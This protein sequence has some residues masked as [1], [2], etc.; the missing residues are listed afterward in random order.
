MAL[1]MAACAAVPPAP[2]LASR[3]EVRHFAFSGRLLIEQGGTRQRLNI[4]WQ[5]LAGEDRILLSTLLGQGVAE[6]GRD[7]GGA[8]V[9]LADRRR[10][11]AADWS[12]LAEQLLGFPLPAGIDGRWLL[13]GTLPASD[14]RWRIVVERMDAEGEALPR[15]ITLERDGLRLTLLIDHWSVLE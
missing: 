15:R 2:T 7:A 5:H 14:G 12:E 1:F 13:T 8:W 11:A 3:A 4:D 9:T 6:L 10:F